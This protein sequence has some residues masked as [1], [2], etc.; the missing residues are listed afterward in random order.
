M[1]CARSRR[2]RRGQAPQGPGSRS[3]LLGVAQAAGTG[4]RCSVQYRPGVARDLARL[5]KAVLRRVDT[6]IIALGADPRPHGCRKLTGTT[7]CWRV[8]VGDWRI[9]YEIDDA[10]RIVEIQI[11]AH[12]RDVY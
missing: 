5:P 9:V 11:V 8:R 6:A 10:R 4:V 3:P 12:R 7:R 2:R 1:G